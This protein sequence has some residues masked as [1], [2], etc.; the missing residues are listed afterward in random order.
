MANVSIGLAQ[1]LMVDIL[2]SKFM[3]K[4]TRSGFAISTY[5]R[6]H[7][8]SADLSASKYGI[9]LNKENRTLQS[10]TQDNVR[11]ALKP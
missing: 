8:I 3:V 9:R 6:Q 2:I 5:K 10:T 4:I 7:G 1:D 11:S